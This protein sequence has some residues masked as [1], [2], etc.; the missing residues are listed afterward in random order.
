MA[1]QPFHPVAA[2]PGASA[3]RRG[4]GPLDGSAQL[5][6]F[7]RGRAR[8]E[9]PDLAVP[10]HDV[11]AEIPPG[12]DDLFQ[13]PDLIEQSRDG[14][15]PDPLSLRKRVLPGVDHVEGIEPVPGCELAYLEIPPEGG[16]ISRKPEAI[17]FRLPVGLIP[18]IADGNRQ[19]PHPPRDQTRRPGRRA[20]M[21]L[22]NYL[23]NKRNNG[24]P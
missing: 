18:R 22:R 19:Y 14:Y 4:E 6:R 15:R 2:S 12:K 5:R 23:I 13:P 21:T 8:E 24:A 3:R 9:R 11:I 10:A 1:A 20:K 7:G 16:G 17:E